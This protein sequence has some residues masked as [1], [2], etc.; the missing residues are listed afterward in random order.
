M[1]VNLYNTTDY[2]NISDWIL[3]E[4]KPNQSQNK[5]NSNPISVK[6][7]MNVNLYVIEDYKNKPRLPAP[8][9]QTQ[10]NPT[11]PGVAPSLC[12]RCKAGTPAPTILFNKTKKMLQIFKKLLIC[13]G[14]YSIIVL[15]YTLYTKRHI[16]QSKMEKAYN[17]N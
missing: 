10:S 1:N 4:N 12:Q 7:K 11:C 9:K 14:F 2:E 5:P 8:G 6:P 3:S 16:Y 13:T 15:F 17:A